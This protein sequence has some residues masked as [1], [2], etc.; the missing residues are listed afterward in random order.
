MSK[1]PL[2]PCAPCS[3]CRSYNSYKAMPRV[4]IEDGI[5]WI[6]CPFCDGATGRKTSLKFWNQRYVKA[7]QDEVAYWLGVLDE[8]AGDK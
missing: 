3:R 8:K 6:R 1:Q 2:D 5:A 7:L 4:K